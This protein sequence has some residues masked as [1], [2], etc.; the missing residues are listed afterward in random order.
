M[1][2]DKVDFTDVAWGSVGWTM[3]C[4]LYL[5]AYESRSEHSILRDHAAAEAVERIEYDFERMRKSLRAS[6]NQYLV[7]L[8][9]RQFDTWTTDF[10]AGHPDAVALHLGCGLDSRA[11]RLDVPAG[12]HWFDVDVPEVMELRRKLYDETDG[13]QM[14]GASVTDPDWL[15]QVPSGRPVLVIAEGLLPYLTGAEVRQ[16]LQRLT[17]RFDTGE[18]LFDGLPPWIVRLT[19]IQH[20]GTRDAH[21]I[22]R[23]NPR[24]RLVDRVSAM[25]R[26]AEI[27]DRR[28][29]RLFRAMNTIRPLRNFSR[30]FRFDWGPALR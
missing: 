16:L 29:R 9:A 11:F 13:Y 6:S 5:R 25:R 19:K 23:W 17:D 10:L 3:L 20:W 27:P 28:Q 15:Q 4:T 8:R 7:A 2:E 12:V 1:A 22:E 30:L 21:E 26:Y 24:L 18:L 14:L